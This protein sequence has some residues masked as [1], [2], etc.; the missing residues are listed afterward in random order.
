MAA[1]AEPTGAREQLVTYPESPVRQSS[2]AK[3][4]PTTGKSPRCEAFVMTGDKI[5]NLDHHVSPNYAKV[6]AFFYFF[7]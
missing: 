3:G 1:V 7:F 4:S 6:S 2:L 5:L